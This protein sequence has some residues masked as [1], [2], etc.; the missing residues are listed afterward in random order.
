MLVPVQFRNLTIAE[1]LAVVM[2]AYPTIDVALAKMAD[3]QSDEYKAWHLLSLGKHV[4]TMHVKQRGKVYQ[5]T[6]ASTIRGTV[7]YSRYVVSLWHDDPLQEDEI[8]VAYRFMYEKWD[9][10]VT[11]PL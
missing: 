2:K 4:G 6:R 10:W 8:N 7:G 9:E 1:F 3:G 5:I 11:I